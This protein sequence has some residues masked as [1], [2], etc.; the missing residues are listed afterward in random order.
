MIDVHALRVLQALDEHGGFTAAAQALG[1][2]Q[3]AVSQLVRRLEKRLSTSLVERAGRSMRLTEPGR[4]LA[5]H[6]VSVLGAL[7]AAEQEMSAIAGLR[8]GR[9]RMMAFPS[10]SAIVVPR[11]L[12]RLRERYPGITV[13]F[14]EAEPPESLVALRSGGCDLAVAFTY[15]PYRSGPADAPNPTASSGAASTD[16][17]TEPGP[18]AELGG[19]LSVPLLK[20][21]VLVA[22]PRRHPVAERKTIPIRQ[23]RDEAWIAGCPQ[24]RRH[25]LTLAG[26][27]GFTPD[28]SFATDDYVAVLGLVAE[29]LG[30]ALIPSLVLRTATHR[31]VV[32]RP[33]SPRS[34]RSVAAVTTPDLFR[35]P[36]VAALVRALQEAAR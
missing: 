21:E 27:A 8:T 1:S 34:H 17:D 12:A 33:L 4:V 3:P 35:V 26:S 18:A 11:A 22:L 32:T 16:A 31:N 28:I 36:A 23:L 2:S 15:S 5:R 24:C 29:G 6:A 13:R 9:V 20:D 19:L 30:V 7:E 14:S 10:S 25:L